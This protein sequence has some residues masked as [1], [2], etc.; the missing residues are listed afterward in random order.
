MHSTRHVKST[1]APNSNSGDEVAKSSHY[2]NQQ[3]NH[4]KKASNYI[5]VADTEVQSYASL[6]HT[7]LYDSNYEHLKS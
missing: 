5:N 1:T 4:A 3:I 2:V 7:D 6:R